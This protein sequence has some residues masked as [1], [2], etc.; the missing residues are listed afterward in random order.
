MAQRH[1]IR[2]FDY[3]NH[4]YARVREALT[5]DAAGIFRA[6][7]RAAASRAESIAAELRVTVAGL[8]VGAAIRV[9]TGE[10]TETR[11]GPH[12]M[13][14]TTIPVY[15]EAASHPELFPFMS[16]D[17]KVYP[18]TST[19]TQVDFLGRYEPPLG[20]LGGALD[21]LVLHRIADASVA[22][23]VADVVRY[24]RAELAKG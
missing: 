24:L 22:R 13:P 21:A 15:W 23:F 9:S 4:P 1:E 8:D 7:T 10:I 12:A 16:A 18:L 19:E 5:A 2:S 14:V 17:M 3:V 11:E 20:I 6:A